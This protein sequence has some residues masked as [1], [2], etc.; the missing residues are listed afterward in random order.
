MG[1]H[2]L[3]WAEGYLGQFIIVIPDENMVV[4]RLGKKDADGD[5]DMYASLALLLYGG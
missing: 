3:F 5:G 2:K 1:K 4:V